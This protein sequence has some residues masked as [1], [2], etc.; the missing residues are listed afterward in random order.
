MRSKFIFFFVYYLKSTRVGEAL[1]RSPWHLCGGPF[2][3][4]ILMI[5]QNTLKPIVLTGGKFF[6]LDYMKVKGILAASFSYYTLLQKLG[7]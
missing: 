5:L 3:R 2:R 4:G 7:D 6:V 1:L